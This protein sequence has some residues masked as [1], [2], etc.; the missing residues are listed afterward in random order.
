MRQNKDGLLAILRTR[1][2]PPGFAQ[3]RLWFLDQLEPGGS[4]YHVPT[5]LR[6]EGELDTAALGAAFTELAA[7]HEALRTRFVAGSDGRPEAVV[8]PPAPLDLPI[9]DVSRCADP[10]AETSRLAGEATRAPF[11]LDLGPLLRARLFRLAPQDHVLLIC[12]HHIA[13]DGWSLGILLGEL[14][15]LC[16]RRRG[17]LPGD[18][19]PD[20]PDDLRPAP[21]PGSF[22]RAQRRWMSTPA[23][24]EQEAW[25]TARLAGA[26]AE[27][28]VPLDRPRPAA[29][30]SEAGRIAA[31]L[32]PEMGA[33]IAALGRREGATSFMVV[34][35]ALFALL[36][37]WSGQTDCC[38][39]CPVAGRDRPEWQHMVGFLVNTLVF[40]E[41]VR[42]DERFQELLG[43]VRSSAVETLSRQ[44][45]PF[46]RV[47]EVAG[48]A[49][50]PGVNPLFQ[51]MLSYDTTRKPAL[52]LGDLNVRRF[53]VSYLASK[54]DLTFE[55]EDDEDGLRAAIEY[56]AGLFE[57][58]S[59][60]RLGAQLGRLLAAVVDDPTLLVGDIALASAEESRMLLAAGAGPDLPV[61]PSTL[62]EAF[63]ARAAAAP[64]ALA[65]IAEGGGLTYAAL[66]SRVS[67]FARSL[68]ASGVRPG[69]LVGLCLERSAAAVVAMLA[70]WRA[71]AAWTPLDPAAPQERLH[72]VLRNAAPR[73]LLALREHAPRLTAMLDQTDI[74]IIAVDA[75][76]IGA[77]AEH[78]GA[79]ERGRPDPGAIAY[80]IYTSGST[81]EP[82]GVVVTHANLANLC[83]AVAH[84]D[85]LIPGDRVLHFASPQFD[86]A[87]EEIAPTLWAGA[88]LSPW[89]GGDAELDPPAFATL[90][91]RRGVTILNLPTAY[92]H[93]LAD[94]TLPPCVRLCVVGGEPASPDALRRWRHRNPLAAWANAYGPTE[95]TVTATTL[96]L[97]P[98]IDA[99]PG[100]ARVAI[101]RPLANIRALV[102]DAA[103]R[104]VAPGIPGE[105]YVGGA[106]VAQGYWRLPALTADRFS[107]LSL[108]G[109]PAARFY[110]TGDRARWTSAGDLE[111]LGRQD[112]QVK[113]R[114]YRIELAE[115]EHALLSHPA[116]NE[117]V[118]ELRRPERPQS[119]G[120]GAGF[121]EGELVAWYTTAR[122]GAGAPPPTQ[123]SLGDHLR[124]RL[125]RFMIPAQIVWL[126]QMPRTA[127]GKVDRRALA[128]PPQPAPEHGKAALSGLEARMLPVWEDLLQRRGCGCDDDFF[129]LG[130]HSLLAVQLVHRL[131]ELLG[132]AVPIAMLL[133]HP[134]L[135]GLAAALD[136]GEPADGS[137][138]CLD[139]LQPTGDRPPLVLAPGGDGNSIG[140]LGLAAAL[141][142]DQPLSA[143]HTPGLAGDGGGFDDLVDLAA[144]F[145]SALRATGAQAPDLWI[146]GWSMG[147]VVALEMAHQLHASGA[148]PRGLIVLDGFFA[149]DVTAMDRLAGGEAR[150]PATLASNDAALM[151]YRPHFALDLDL[152]YVEPAQDFAPLRRA[153]VRRRW[154]AAARRPI[155]FW[156]APGDHFTMLRPPHV[157]A[158]AGVVRAI[159]DDAPASTHPEAA[160]T[161]T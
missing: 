154:Q 80:V 31:P 127:G 142:A 156:T 20:L 49:R 144:H 124:A 29:A 150:P 40:R 64:D 110:R 63:A 112:H 45:L 41:I 82:K 8:D 95:A 46:D 129:A 119:G 138:G 93:L 78:A 149:E 51:V 151:G 107:W 39:G 89:P 5:A 136:A 117:A 96:M 90:V 97:R 126:E 24:R 139:T 94:M 77:G 10:L 44:D 47:V 86:V 7:R 135:R 134:T 56:D 30:G 81:G 114:G 160:W 52:R 111:F 143:F 98:G 152:H 66:D 132:R 141:G 2:D 62:Q 37:R 99:P 130:G 147:G 103:Q 102:L 59:I 58:A 15:H 48:A 85:G 6:L 104:P 71:G 87:L 101:G 91:A 9:T 76:A 68:A 11:R 13:V 4:R 19:P 113:L 28:A 122:L 53:D 92:W 60:V 121:A 153:E 43:R 109:E 148:P 16:D 54:F 23:C 18:F 116:V 105:L 128:L 67:R 155:R 123:A 75:A 133:R 84:R 118:V 50:R 35:A 61:S 70:I 159:M 140:F 79:P 108:Q 120:S 115:V 146:G 33:R 74:S 42:P 25:W 73:H 22:A 72:F 106:G 32:A 27:H 36:H 69:D 100:S 14:S 158:L 57:S 157:A 145:C 12:I 3:E 1:P 34:L 55:F 38:L 21:Q 88:A 131:R 125:P 65:V 17:G 26:P 83:V 161:T 137:A